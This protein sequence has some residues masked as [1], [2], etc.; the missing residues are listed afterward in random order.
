M[1]PVDPKIIAKGFMLDLFAEIYPE[2]L[3]TALMRGIL[4]DVQAFT[5][6]TYGHKE[7][8][9]KARAMIEAAEE[10]EQS[11]EP[12]KKRTFAKKAVSP[13]G[14]R[15]FGSDPWTPARWRYEI[16][17]LAI[18]NGGSF[19]AEDIREWYLTL[20][21]GVHFSSTRSY[22]TI[23]ALK[24]SKYV[25]YNQSTAVYTLTEKGRLYFDQL[26]RGDTEHETEERETTVPNLDL[27]VQLDEP[28]ESSAPPESEPQ[29]QPISPPQR[30]GIREELLQFA[31]ENNDKIATATF[32]ENYKVKTGRK[33]SSSVVST[34]LNDPRYFARVD[35]GMYR[36]TSAGK[37]TAATL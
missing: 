11:S 10:S 9:S 13:R 1:H 32:R 6:S 22:S 21:T 27:K 24:L 26:S 34:A 31:R 18:R 30:R 2:G 16:L 8:N 17:S 14:S 33:L 29:S 28:V 4:S 35:R 23:Q 37:K 19:K 25:D 36:L 12:K 15:T 20:H 5:N 3:G 7:L